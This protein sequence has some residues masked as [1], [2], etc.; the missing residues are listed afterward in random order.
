MGH[1]RIQRTDGVVSLALERGKVNALDHALVRELAELVRALELDAEVRALVLTGAGKFFS[2]GFDIPALYPLPKDEFA[3]FVADFAA[4]YRAIY[5]WRKP[6]VAA[7][8]GHA[9][10]GGCMLALACDRRVM[11]GGTGAKISLNEIG[12]GSSVFAGATAMLRAWVGDAAAARV[13]YS[14]AMFPAEEARALGL[15]C[16][17]VDAASLTARAAAVAGQMSAAHPPAFAGIKGLLHEPVA[18]QFA[19]REAASIEEFVEIWYSEHTR[20]RLRE[21]QIRS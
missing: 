2:F 10:A 9:I 8:N 20:A 18:A 17:V 14:G 6:V 15:V 13:L 7:I 5:L 21:I 19:P 1:V 16:E 11:V 12:F 3:A 4:L